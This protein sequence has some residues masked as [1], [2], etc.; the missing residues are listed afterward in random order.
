MCNENI[1]RKISNNYS[2]VWLNHEHDLRSECQIV[3]GIN[4]LLNIDEPNGFCRYI[5]QGLVILIWDTVT[6]DI[7]EIRRQSYIIN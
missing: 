3:K 2:D 6:D 1:V 5:L 4:H 7:R